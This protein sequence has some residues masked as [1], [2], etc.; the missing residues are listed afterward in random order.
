MEAHELRIGNYYMFA[1]NDGICYRA[2]KQIKINEFGFMS[3]YDGVNFGICKPIPLTEEWLMRFGFLAKNIHSNFILNEIEIASSV[4][5][6]ATN[7]RRSF[8]LDGEI[9]E[10]MK[11]KIETVHQLQNLYFSLTQ[12]E[13]TLCN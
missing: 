11:I 5:V 12:K 8:Y 13:L 3:D 1:D 4:R 7:E 9:P 10:S 6:I 2:V